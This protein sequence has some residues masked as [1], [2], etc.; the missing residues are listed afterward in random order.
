MKR[1]RDN[2]RNSSNVRR[3]QPGGETGI[4]PGRPELLREINAR[5][6]LRLLRQHGPCSRAD[7]VRY[8][9]LSAPTISSGVAYLESRRL[10]EPMGPGS[11]S[12][13]RP[14]S[15]LRF[16]S[17]LGYVAGVDIGTSVVRV[18]LA[19]LNGSI[20]DRWSASTR[21]HSTPERVAALVSTGIRT[22]QSHHRLPAKRLLALAAGVPG[23]TDARAGVVLSAPILPSGWQAVPLQQMLET[24]TGIPSRIENDVNLAAC[25]ESRLGTARGVRNFVFL[26][27]GT[28]VGAG[29]FV[30]GRLY[31]GADWTAGEIGYLYVPGTEETPLALGRPGSLESIIGVRGIRSAWQRLCDPQGPHGSDGA[32]RSDG[33]R[34]LDVTEIFNLAQRGESPARTILHQTARILADAI[35]NVCVILNS[36]LVILG[37]RIGSHPALFEATRRIVEHNDFARPRLAQSALGSEAPLHGAVG[38]ALD[39]AEE[40]IL[41]SSTE[42]SRRLAS[43]EGSGFLPPFLGLTPPC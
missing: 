1:L 41:P 42:A 23:I 29:I 30:D 39:A 3:L 35:T 37:G 5:Q 17:R 14:P 38:L 18:A 11:S 19:D 36:S 2:G 12:G 27:I 40:R 28:G 26:T 34:A 4:G 8:S 33:R 21:A 43:S 24:A 7:L 20:I 25:G 6:V 32:A 9:G 10:V 22:L 16:N 31:H 13:G 15:L